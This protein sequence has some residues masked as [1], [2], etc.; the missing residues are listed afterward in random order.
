M[1]QYPECHDDDDDDEKVLTELNILLSFSDQLDRIGIPTDSPGNNEEP[2][3]N[4]VS[5]VVSAS[6]TNKPPMRF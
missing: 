5:P 2:R 4:I 1:Y 3:S 6:Y